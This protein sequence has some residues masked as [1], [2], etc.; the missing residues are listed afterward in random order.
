MIKKS[1]DKTKK[2]SPKELLEREAEGNHG[3]SVNISLVDIDDLKAFNHSIILAVDTYIY[4]GEAK[5]IFICD[6]H[7]NLCVVKIQNMTQRQ[8]EDMNVLLT[9]DRT[10][11]LKNAKEIVPLLRSNQIHIN[12]NIYDVHTVAKVIDSGQNTISDYEYIGRKYLGVSGRGYVNFNYGI[13][14]YQLKELA[15]SLRN[16]HWLK[17]ILTV[18]LQ[19]LL[20]TDTAKLEFECLPIILKLEETGIGFDLEKYKILIK[21]KREKLKALESEIMHIVGD[22][23]IKEDDS[24]F[25]KIQKIKGGINSIT[26]SQM[27]PSDNVQEANRLLAECKKLVYLLDRF[28]ESFESKYDCSTQKIYPK[29]SQIESTTGRIY[30]SNPNLQQFPRDKEFRACIIPAASCKF[31]IADYSQIELRIAAEISKDEAMINAFQE[32]Q[33]IHCTTAAVITNKDID[34]I[35]TEERRAA[36]AVNFGL[37]FGMS[38]EGLQRYAESNYQLSLALEEAKGFKQR[39]FE[40]YRGIKD[41]Q[42]QCRQNRYKKV[43]RT[44]NGRRRVWNDYPSFT[45]FLSAP[46]QGSEADILKLALVKLDSELKDYNA[47]VVLVVHDEI[48]VEVAAE[49]AEDVKR[50]VVR[51]M[52]EAGQTLLRKVP[53]EVKAAIGDS[54]A[55]K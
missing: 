13:S 51:C 30:C 16:L 10:K 1:S 35:S 3:D 24:G 43:S 22:V 19:K 44:L 27:L 48:I 28:N 4:K 33:D 53:V 32:G 18:E 21:S 7:G 23:G 17:D 9:S 6:E 46:I 15:K 37:I 49:Q 54:W 5:N 45:K 20:L 42:E 26:A 14:D 39:F 2:L 52:V 36:K 47:N 12:Q 38:S 34:S 55:D 31:V 41:W 40:T 25:D 29:Y 50:I 11:I 8:K